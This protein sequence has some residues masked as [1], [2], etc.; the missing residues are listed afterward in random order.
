M[1]ATRSGLCY[2]C[3][4]VRS[5]YITVVFLKQKDLTVGMARVFFFVNPR[6]EP[7]LMLHLPPSPRALFESWI[8]K[9][10]QQWQLA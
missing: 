9:R 10:R 6:G 5:W 8:A 4:E 2:D 1:T 3:S 7:S